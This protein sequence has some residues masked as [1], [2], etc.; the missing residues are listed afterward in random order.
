MTNYTRSSERE[1]LD[2]IFYQP[3]QKSTE[4]SKFLLTLTNVAQ[5]VMHFLIGSNDL[6]V[7]ET[8]DRFGNNWWHAYDPLT[9]RSI[10]VESE[11]E[12]RA[13]IEQ[14]YYQ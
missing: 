9:G 5:R 4:K 11:S 7:W 3:E 13:W 10:T 14:R 2:K 1:K 6:R 8:Y 12:L